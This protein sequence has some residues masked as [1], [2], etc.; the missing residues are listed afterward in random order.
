MIRILMPAVLLIATQTSLADSFETA[1][2]QAAMDRTQQEVTYD[3]SYFTI[4][5]P[6]GDVPPHLGVC[7]DVI[8]RS[9]RALGADLQLLVH[10]DMS[11]HFEAY[12]SRRIWGLTRPDSNIDHRRVPNLRVFFA[13]H[14]Q[15]LPVTDNPRDYAPGD[16]VSWRLPGDLPHIGIVTDQRSEITGHPLVVHNIGTG[17]KLEDRLF[18]YNITGHYRYVPPNYS[19]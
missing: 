4:P 7:T 9:Y 16:V 19:E 10:E 13:R 17:P 11:G 2:F 14:G 15:R 5:Y 1:L 8:I 12:P 6:N 18:S 3:G